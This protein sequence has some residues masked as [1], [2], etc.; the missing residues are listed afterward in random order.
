MSEAL[1]LSGK[2]ALVTGASRG[3]G[4]GI[5]LALARRGADVAVGCRAGRDA[6][7]QV[8]A[9]VT[10]LGRRAQVF[11]ADV[12]VEAEVARMVAAVRETLGPADILVAN[13]G[14]AVPRRIEDV[15]AQ[16]FNDT[17]ATNL[18]SAFYCAQAVLPDMR[19][20]H[21]GRLVFIS[22]VA[23]QRGGI[24]GPHYA[25]SKAGMHGLA[26]FY[27]AHLAREGVTANVVAPALVSTDMVSD[28]PVA[29]PDFLP[30]GRFGTVEE[31]ASIVVA[32][33]ENGY[34]TGQTVSVN[35]GWYMT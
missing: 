26:H 29:R 19:R 2:V 15:T 11:P 6:A 30:V 20:R 31:T 13:A 4:R 7:A 16:E 25:A 8:A 12:A 9:A 33:V 35:G 24:V 5:A 1:P 28:N 3:I 34:V 27:A 23:A 14:V 17:L 22:S 10:A 18:S 32:L 21:F